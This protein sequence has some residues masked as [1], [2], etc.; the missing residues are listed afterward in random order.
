MSQWTTSTPASAPTRS[1]HS[2]SGR[3]M[4][5]MPATLPGLLALELLEVTA[6]GPLGQGETDPRVPGDLQARRAGGGVG[7]GG[8]RDSGRG[9]VHGHSGLLGSSDRGSRR[10]GPAMNKG[11]GWQRS[12][13][14]PSKV[15]KPPG[16]AG[17]P[18]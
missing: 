5:G 15:F 8:R 6:G 12:P 16:R 17:I 10:V 1:D 7:G 2:A 18:Q 11:V 14:L 3:E 13:R 4:T 9:G